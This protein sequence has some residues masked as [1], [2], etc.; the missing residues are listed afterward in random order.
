MTNSVTKK[1]LW[2]VGRIG[3][4]DPTIKKYYIDGGVATAVFKGDTVKI[5]T[6]SST[7]DDRP[8]VDVMTAAS[9]DFLGS[10]VSTYDS[11]GKPC[12]YLAASTAGYVDVCIDHDAIYEVKTEDGGTALTQAAAGDCADLVWTHAGSTTTGISGVEL[13]ETLAGDGASAQFRIID[14]VHSPGND[15]AS[16]DIRMYV[17]PNEHAN[18]Y[19]GVAV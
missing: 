14:K 8:T 5:V 19:D 13:S 4:G 1:G 3:G 12:K 17:T 2:P 10:V 16:H 11:D 18:K 9:D 6:D 15:W 7:S